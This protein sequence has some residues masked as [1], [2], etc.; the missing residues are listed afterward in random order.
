MTLWSWSRVF[1]AP[2]DKVVVPS[3]LPIVDS[4][5]SECI[6][7]IFDIVERR[8]TERPLEQNF[9]SVP[10]IAI[11]EPWKSLA[12]RNTPGPLPPRIPLFLA[13]GTNDDLVQ[14]A[15]TKAYFQRQCRAGGK[16]TLLLLPGVGHG[17]AGRD[18]ANAA[19]IWMGERF[20]GNPA[21]SDC[22]RSS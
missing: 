22:G 8:R 20:A 17:F 7:S 19:V 21:P 15:V 18:A 11:T 12:A 3:A 13:Q 6:E 10:N 9:L 14:P 4:L 1:A 2:I 16:V 5:A